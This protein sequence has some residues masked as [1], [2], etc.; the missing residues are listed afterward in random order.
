MY[1][2]TSTEWRV[3][4]ENSLE[5]PPAIAL[6]FQTDLHK[7]TQA[8]IHILWKARNSAVHGKT[9]PS[10]LWE[11]RI[12]EEAIHTWKS[13]VERKGQTMVEGA[14]ARIRSLP[15]K[16][17]LKW[18]KN[19]LTKQKS[20]T[21][22]WSKSQ[23]PHVE[24]EIGI[25]VGGEP[26]A[27][28]GAVQP[29]DLST[30]AQRREE[31][32][33]ERNSSQ[34]SKKQCTMEKFFPKKDQAGTTTRVQE[35]GSISTNKKRTAIVANQPKC[36]NLAGTGREADALERQIE[37]DQHQIGEDR[38]NSIRRSQLQRTEE[39]R[40]EALGKLQ[41]RLKERQESEE[42]K[43]RELEQEALGKLQQ[44]LKEMQDSE[45]IKLRELEQE[46][47]GKLKQRLKERQESEEIKLR[48]LEQDKRKKRHQRTTK[49]RP[50]QKRKRVIEDQNVFVNSGLSRRQQT[51]GQDGCAQLACSTHKGIS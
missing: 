35:K 19:R 4:L 5:I 48:E 6:K 15:S 47:R 31:H 1:G 40:L 28:R 18:V 36:K 7:C 2:I 27:G 16:Q 12:F 11:L 33:Q 20:I 9:T 41:Q 29:P 13:E 3:F 50:D 8:A 23:A 39:H 22:F 51:N 38:I 17:K 43:L 25:E 45:E 32:R 44:R 34:P 30:K 46:A 10:E 49:Y 42:L 37:D 21:E 14:E 24:V 26:Q